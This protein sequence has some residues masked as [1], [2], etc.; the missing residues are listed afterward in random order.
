MTRGLIQGSL[1]GPISFI[2]TFD[3]FLRQLQEI[4]TTNLQVFGFVDDATTAAIENCPDKLITSSILLKAPFAADEIKMK[5]NGKK[6]QVLVVDF[7]RTKKS[8]HW[9]F[10]VNEVPV[11]TVK[12]A[13]LLG[14]IVNSQLTWDDHVNSIITKASSRLWLLR[15]LRKFGFTKIELTLLYKSSIIPILEYASP[16]W[17]YAITTSQVEAI[18]RVQWRAVQTICNKKIKFNSP[19]YALTL[20]SLELTSLCIRREEMAL[21]F[22]MSLLKSSS[23][24][25]WLPPFITGNRQLRKRNLL[26]P[27]KARTVRYA[28]SIIPYFVEIINEKSQ[29]CP[30]LFV[31][32]STQI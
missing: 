10:H 28:K 23:F 21:S 26:N 19:D 12:S 18:E 22:A 1:N 3:P 5:L 4:D 30:E 32:I 20:L 6:T 16:V 8:Q 24:R 31:S 13:R 2:L 14:V 29:Q 25:C 27:I 15:S 11:D 17:G 9:Q 7:T